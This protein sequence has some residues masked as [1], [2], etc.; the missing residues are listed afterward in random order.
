[1]KWRKLRGLAG[2]DTTDSYSGNQ[3]RVQS[4]VSR[5][6][7]LMTSTTTS[8]IILSAE[9]ATHLAEALIAAV[10]DAKDNEEDAKNG[11]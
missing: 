11:V 6:C 2:L 10:K 7:V 5:G 4:D 8:A 3:I 9:A 1:M